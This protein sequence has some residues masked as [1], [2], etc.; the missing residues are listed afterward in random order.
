ME[1]A[2][3]KRPMSRQLVENSCRNAEADCVNAA[4]KC[5]IFPFSI[6]VLYES[7]SNSVEPESTASFTSSRWCAKI[8]ASAVPA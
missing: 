3:Y 6:A 4:D 2:P 7:E 8:V 1:L 5:F